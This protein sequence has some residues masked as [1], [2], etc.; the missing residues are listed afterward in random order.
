M[1]NRG[2]RGIALFFHGRGTRRGR[3][4]SLT[5]WPL[6]TPEKEQVPIVQE[7]GWAPDPV[8]TGAENLASRRDSIPGPSNILSKAAIKYRTQNVKVNYKQSMYLPLGNNT[9]CS[10]KK[11]LILLIF[12]SSLLGSHFTDINVLYLNG[13]PDDDT[14]PEDNGGGYRI[15]TKRE[16]N[17][18]FL[19]LCVVDRAF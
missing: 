11:S 15:C 19:F 12:N 7:A 4:V 8:W 6:F 3:R 18:H 10:T 5:P 13:F 1:V 16:E 14:P 17:R 9:E 2:S